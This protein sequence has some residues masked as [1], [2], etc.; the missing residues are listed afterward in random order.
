VLSTYEISSH[1]VSEVIDI[2][3]QLKLE[4]FIC[5]GI[6]PQHFSIHAETLK[7]MLRNSGR[8][9]LDIYTYTEENLFLFEHSHGIW[10]CINRCCRNICSSRQYRKLQMQGACKNEAYLFNTRNI[11]HPTCKTNCILYV[12]MQPPLWSTGQS[13]WL[14][15]LRSRF[16][17]RRYQILGVTRSSEK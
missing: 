7:S 8:L 3:P 16:D 4:S 2:H 17:S 11:H 10:Q 12:Y 6:W 5:Y 1:Q 14:R 9:S 15:I 13:S